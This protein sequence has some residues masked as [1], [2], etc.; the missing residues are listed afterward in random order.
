MRG[1]KLSSLNAR[2]AAVRNALLKS[3]RRDLRVLPV[4]VTA[5]TA[6]EIQVDLPDAEKSGILVLTRENIDRAVNELRRY[7]DANRFFEN[8]WTEV[9][10]KRLTRAKN[11]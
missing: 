10:R 8:A 7:P 11:I 3:E 6:A 5:M 9:E 2:A 1:G 4:I